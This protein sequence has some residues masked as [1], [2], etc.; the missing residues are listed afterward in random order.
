MA[1]SIQQRLCD[2]CI[3][4]HITQDATVK[5]PE[6]EEY[7]CDKCKIHHGIAKASSN[8]EIISIDNDL[9]LP[10]F[11]QNIKNNC[12]DHD[13]RFVLYCDDHAV[14]CCT[15]C[16]HNAHAG[17]R[18]L[19]SLHIVV[20]NAKDS[21]LLMDLETTLSDLITNITNIIEDRTKNLLDFAEQKMRCKKEIKITRDAL[22]TY[23][24][25]LEVNLQDDLQKTFTENEVMIQ[26][27]L[28]DFELQKY[29]VCEMREDVNIVKSTASRFQS[30]LVIRELTKLANTTETGL[31]DLYDRGSFN[32]IEISNGTTILQS[33]KNN[34]KSFGKPN[35]RVNP[36]KIK[37]CVQKTRAA[38]LIGPLKLTN[39]PRSKAKKA[40]KRGT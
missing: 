2:I 22:N 21:P 11:V 35:V 28:K 7:F 4:Q 24:D 32:W 10:K 31:Q 30:F 39:T 12:S 18:N 1:S 14:P 8:H 29:K 36:S 20:E 16:I 23:F 27:M 5:C 13:E 38:Q 9:K 19:T 40:K 37:L 26:N 33:V 15:K 34:L 17:C 6:C 3:N 25:V